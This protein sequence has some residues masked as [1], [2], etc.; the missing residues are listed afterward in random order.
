MLV[1][2][3]VN[4]FVD[5]AH[6]PDGL[7]NSLKT[8]RKVTKNRLICVFGCGGNRDVSKRAVMGAVAGRLADL[9]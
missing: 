5:Y 9:R 3:G 6:T 7:E 2:N 8:L 1:K 4:V